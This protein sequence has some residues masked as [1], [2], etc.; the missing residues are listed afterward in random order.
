M[1]GDWSVRTLEPSDCEAA[2][3]FW[4]Q[5]PGLGLSTA[6]K[7][8]ALE[9][10]LA[11][12]PGLSWVVE[13]DD[14]LVGTVLSGHDG[15]RGFIYHLAVARGLRGQGVG[16]ALMARALN[17][18]AAAGIEKCHLMVAAGNEDGLGFWPAVGAVERTDIVLF[19]TATVMSAS[20]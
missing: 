6:D 12:N 17:G 9:R 8:P 3:G 5:T 1:I 16:R 11:R 4:L 19:S 7:I 15:R 13:A 20:S 18:R 14:Q 2:V 10:F